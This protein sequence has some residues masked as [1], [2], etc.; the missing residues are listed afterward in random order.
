[1]RFVAF[2]PA[3]VIACLEG[4]DDEG[5]RKKSG[6]KLRYRVSGGR[7]TVKVR[8]KKSGVGRKKRV[9][10]EENLSSY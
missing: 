9:A 10:G 8:K 4:Q 5:R 1:M 2:L 7:E 6:V 3:F